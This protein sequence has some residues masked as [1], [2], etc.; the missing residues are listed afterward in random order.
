M[1][2]KGKTHKN[3]IERAEQSSFALLISFPLHVNKN[4][5]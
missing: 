3:G 5:L 2:K 1:N 4:L